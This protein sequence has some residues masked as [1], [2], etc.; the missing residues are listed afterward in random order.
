MKKKIFSVFF[1][2]WLEYFGK[3][4]SRKDY[5]IVRVCLVYCYTAKMLKTLTSRKYG[6]NQQRAKDFGITEMVSVE[7]F[8]YL[9][10][11]FVGKG[12]D[13]RE[14][15]WTT[16]G[17]PGARQEL[18]LASLSYYLATII[19]ENATI[20]CDIQYMKKIMYTCNRVKFAYASIF[21]I[22]RKDFLSI[23]PINII[24]CMIFYNY[25][26]CWRIYGQHHLYHYIFLLKLE[27]FKLNLDQTQYILIKLMSRSE[28]LTQELMRFENS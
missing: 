8:Y 14:A 3:R 13:M 10:V 4:L 7:A 11:R 5:L 16:L 20:F 1:L 12:E 19:Q 26:I 9:L 15:W 25:Y 18:S 23:P 6:W 24:L 21:C 17:T 22:R 27:E 2:L 28:M